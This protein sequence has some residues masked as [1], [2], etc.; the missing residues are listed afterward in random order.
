MSATK[1]TSPP[2]G[3]VCLFVC[4]EAN[5]FPLFL[6]LSLEAPVTMLN[7]AGYIFCCSG[8]FVYNYIKL[9]KMKKKDK[10]IRTRK[11]TEGDDIESN[12]K[13]STMRVK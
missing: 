2:T 5:V 10:M 1:K 8:V 13:P 11:E 6:S 9:Q 4:D 7:L 12:S 3:L